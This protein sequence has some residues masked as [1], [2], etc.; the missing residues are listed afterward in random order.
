MS[1]VWLPMETWHCQTQKYIAAH[2]ASVRTDLLQNFRSIYSSWHKFLINYI[3]Q[4]SLHLLFLIY[5]LR[6]FPTLPDTVC[7]GALND[8]LFVISDTSGLL[9]ITT[10]SNSVF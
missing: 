8:T 10:Q 9:S 1:N 7:F 5:E 3:T 6:I 4:F 2:T